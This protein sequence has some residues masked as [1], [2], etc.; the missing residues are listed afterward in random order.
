VREA[1]TENALS[2]TVDSRDG[3]KISADVDDDLSHH[4]GLMLAKRRSSS[5]RYY[6]ATLCRQR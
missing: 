6:S 2:L 4:L 3:G 1:A 5:P